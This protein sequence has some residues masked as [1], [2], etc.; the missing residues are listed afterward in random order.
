MRFPFPNL[1][2]NDFYKDPD[3]VREFA[4]SLNYDCTKGN[5]PGLRSEEI[6]LID[7]EFKEQCGKKLLSILGDYDDSRICHYNLNTAFQKIWRFSSDPKDPV[8]DG[9]IHNDGLCPLAAVIYLDPD[10]V[11]DNGTS[12]Y[13]KDYNLPEEERVTPNNR[14]QWYNDILGSEDLSSVDSLKPYRKS[15]VKNNNQ[16]SLTTEV[17]NRYN[18]AII[19][20]GAQWHG[21]TSYY[22]PTD[23]DFRL[24]QVF[25]FFEMNIPNILVPKV[26]CK[27]YGI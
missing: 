20:S 8:N 17:K 26:R 9:W 21:Q 3:S 27:S 12:V 5:H 6:G 18:R 11:N 15:I 14:P 22:M 2:F 19:Y 1:T 4:L 23:D 25:F 7:K 16:F 13:I 24:T 10:P